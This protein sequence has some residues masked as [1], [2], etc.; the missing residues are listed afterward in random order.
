MKERKA[1][2]ARRYITKNSPKIAALAELICTGDK[3][4]FSDYEALIGPVAA[5]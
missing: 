5:E 2:I 1:K 3:S 4:T